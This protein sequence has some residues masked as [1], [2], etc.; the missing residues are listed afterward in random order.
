MDGLKPGVMMWA[1]HD[2][3][4]T[5]AAF[6]VLGIRDFQLGIP[7]DLPLPGLAADWKAALTDANCTIHTVFMAYRGESYADVGTVETTVGF[8]PQNTRSAREARSHAVVDFAHELGAPGIATHIGCL[9]ADPSDGE[10]QAVLE[11]VSPN[12]R[13]RQPHDFRARNRPGKR[14]C[15]AYVSRSRRHARILESIS[16]PR[17]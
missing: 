6:T 5:L 14:H 7:G 9:P 11:M 17:T 16:I 1:G 2:P 3:A 13:S 12:C 10:Y 15:P 4:Q 8:V